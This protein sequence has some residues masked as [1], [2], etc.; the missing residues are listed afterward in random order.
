MKNST[1]AIFAAVLLGLSGCAPA[2][3]TL[4]DSLGDQGSSISQV[5]NGETVTLTLDSITESAVNA[6]NQR[7]VL[8]FNYPVDAATVDQGINFYKLSS[9]ASTFAAYT[10]TAIT[11]TAEISGNSVI[12]TLDLNGYTIDTVEVELVATVL[13]GRRGTAK[14]DANGNQT[15]GEA[16]DTTITTFGIGLNQSATP[17]LNALGTLTGQLANPSATL[18]VNTTNRLAAN[19]VVDTATYGSNAA[20][21]L[22]FTVQ[23]TGSSAAPNGITLGTGAV[24]VYRNN[25][26]VW[27]S[28]TATTT[29]NTADFT[30]TIALNSPA[31]GETYKIV[32]NRYEIYETAAV[33][34]YVHRASYDQFNR[35]GARDV[36]RYYIFSNPGV[37][38]AT[39]PVITLGGSS[40]AYYLDVTT[41]EPINMATL[42]SS[43]MKLYLSNVTIAGGTTN[44]SG[45]FPWTSAVLETSTGTVPSNELV[46]SFRIYL[47][48]SILVTTP[49]LGPTVP[50]TGSLRFAPS[51]LTVANATTAAENK[52]SFGNVA[53]A[54]DA[55]RVI[56]F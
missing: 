42:T 6:A 18:T 22:T 24:T 21:S 44:V 46:R 40:G 3:I 48:S 11:K 52:L 30:A 38:T 10:R 13:T 53:A 2:T 1:I 32:I 8:N 55:W 17:A 7:V 23:D 36:V 45:F 27:T 49:A 51:V 39:D 15:R 56:T 31:I 25:A 19:A 35:G 47:P 4:G 41:T 37:N 28:V 20:N 34:N 26:G 29:Y 5:N 12:F 9:G 33:R 54:N 43:S 14:L 16:G 50:P